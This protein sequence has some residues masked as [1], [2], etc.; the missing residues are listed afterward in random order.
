MG[1]GFTS[2]LYARF[3]TKGRLWNIDYT[4]VFYFDT[5]AKLDF[6]FVK[7]QKGKVWRMI[8]QIILAPSVR[9]F[10]QRLTIARWLVLR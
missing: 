3:S 6:T 10:Y 1:E 7:I 8:T 9:E 2:R 5:S 4:I